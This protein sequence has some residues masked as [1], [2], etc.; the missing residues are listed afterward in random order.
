MNKRLLII[1]LSVAIFV[2]CKSNKTTDPSPKPN[3]STDTVKDAA[4][5]II[6]KWHYTADTVKK[7][8]NRVLTQTDPTG[9]VTSAYY[10]QF[11]ADSTGVSSNGAGANAFFNYSISDNS[12]I[13]N[14]PL[15]T[16]GG[17]PV[18]ASMETATIKK[19]TTNAMMLFFDD[20]EID[21]N[22][23]YRTTRAAYFSR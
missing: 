4:K 12:I 14:T 23:D 13:I 5:L 9:G 10:M 8:V 20:E 22:V 2:G 16:V 19:I 17:I 3:Q 21:D 7:Y 15:Q 18:P 1:V 11:N 6:G